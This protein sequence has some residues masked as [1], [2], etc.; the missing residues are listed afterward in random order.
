MDSRS[1]PCDEESTKKL[2]KPGTIFYELVAINA[3]DSKK[4]QK[5]QNPKEVKS[6]DKTPIP[7]IKTQ[8]ETLVSTPLKVETKP[9]EQVYVISMFKAGPI[10]DGP[11]VPFKQIMFRR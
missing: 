5:P 7:Q 4:H 2:L 1:I 11:A 9:T 3:R 10:T 8:P 6:S